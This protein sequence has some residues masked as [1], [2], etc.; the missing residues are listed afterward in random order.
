MRE[1]TLD[2]KDRRSIDLVLNSEKDVEGLL[3]YPNLEEVHLRTPIRD[4][5]YSALKEL[6]HLKT[7]RVYSYSYGEKLSPKNFGY[8]VSNIPNLEYLILN[9]KPVTNDTIQII[10]TLRSLK[11]L[12]FGFSKSLDTNLSTLSNCINLIDLGLGSSRQRQEPPN[13]SFLHSLSELKHLRLSFRPIDLNPLS[14]CHKLLE[15]NLSNNELENV[16]LNS[17]SSCTLLEQLDLSSNHLREIDLS[18]LS[19]C[20]ELVQV[21][22]RYNRLKEID[23]TPLSSC[24]HLRTL[25]LS[26]NRLVEVDLSPLRNADLETLDL[27]ENQLQSINLSGL[28]GSH[29]L[30]ALHLDENKLKRID[31]SPLIE[32]KILRVLRLQENKLKEIDLSP[33]AGCLLERLDLRK[34]PLAEIDLTS[35]SNTILVDVPIKGSS[36]VETGEKVRGGS[37]WQARVDPRSVNKITWP[38]ACIGCGKTEGPFEYSGFSWK[39]EERSEEN[40]S[41][42]QRI[43][44]VRVGDNIIGKLYLNPKLFGGIGLMSSAWSGVVTNFHMS[45]LFGVCRSCKKNNREA[46]D[47]VDI[48]VHF[49]FKSKQTLFTV[50]FSSE[51]YAKLF[52]QKNRCRKP[53]E[54]PS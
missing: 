15:L 51:E 45:Y 47:F 23:L 5:D 46:T 39:R 36:G 3:L 29:N 53:T 21:N 12:M 14:N 38:R 18:P 22:F 49:D 8:L 33:L 2:G 37:I 20:T 48:G 24:H 6:T 44:Y 11:R 27:Y 7:L 30:N 31:L 10:S 34:N 54:L 9:T 52:K 17:L 40:T 16:S 42:F 25:N 32:C 43:L 1:Q 4:I 50:T 26:R 35:I 13:L 28:S 19:P 41:D